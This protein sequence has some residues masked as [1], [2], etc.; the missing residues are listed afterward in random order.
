MGLVDTVRDRL[1]SQPTGRDTGKGEGSGENEP[2]PGYARLKEGDVV[3]ELSK[4][5]QTE[6]QSIEEY[7]RAHKNRGAVL[8]KLRY[9]RGSEPFS[10]Y[11]SVSVEEVIDALESAD[12]DTIKKV[13]GYERK[14]ANRRDV[15][16]AVE[17]IHRTRRAEEPGSAPRRR[18]APGASR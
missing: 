10:D 7:E 4:H 1:S 17:R 14:F 5:S 11:D 6:L 18:E 15:L 16:E 8:A 13:R 9:M 12:T 2:V 3:R